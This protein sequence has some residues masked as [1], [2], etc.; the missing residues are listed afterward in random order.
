MRPSILIALIGTLGC[1]DPEPAE[2]DTQASG[3]C[4]YEDAETDTA[5]EPKEPAS[6]P[7]SDDLRVTIEV[8]GTGTLSGLEPACEV[9]GATGGFTGL[10]EGSGEIDGNGTYVALLA[11]NEATFTTPSGT[12]DIP[13]LEIGSVTSVVVRGELTNTQT[14]C[15]TYCES[16]ARAA[17]EE[18]CGADASA[19]SCRTEFE[20][21]YESTCTQECTTSTRTIVAET[22]LGL[23]AVAAI[24][25]SGLTGSGLGEIEADLTFDHIEEADG[26]E[27]DEAQ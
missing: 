7:P 19:A 11:S 16:K 13:E 12:C 24:N 23:D 3:T 18:S 6:P 1:A 14:N 8:A 25:A 20:G 15:E 9:E 27:V 2:G 5:G 4:A 10:L 17:A 26:T 22:S 21:S